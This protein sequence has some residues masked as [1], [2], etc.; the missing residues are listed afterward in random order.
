MA[1]TSSESQ[2]R[3]VEQ[4]GI[5]VID[6]SERKGRPRELFW[7]W[8]AANISVLGDQLRRVRARVRHL[9]LAGAWSPQ[10]SAS[11]SLPALS[12]SSPSPASAA[13]RRRWCS[14]A[15]R[16]AS[17][18]RAAGLVS[19][20]LLVGWE[21]VLVSLG[22][23]GHRDRLRPSSAGAAAT[24]QGRRAGRGRRADRRGGVLGFDVIMRLQTWITIV[25]A[26][27][28]VGLHD[29]DPRRHQ[30]GDASP[31]LPAARPQRDRRAACS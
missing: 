18:Q 8:F 2:S 12:G 1:A 4:N 9:V 24:H 28:T 27:L 15:R 25:T 19:W 29:A 10:W 26:V 14:A 13:R 6:E 22:D 7:P 20:L 30:L 11:S 21:T 31:A 23:A 3:P 17:R 5:N 16:S